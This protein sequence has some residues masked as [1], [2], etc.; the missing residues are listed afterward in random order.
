[1]RKFLLK[2]LLVAVGAAALLLL[3][4][5]IYRLDHA[6]RYHELDKFG[7]IAGF[8]DRILIANVGS[9]HGEYDFSYDALRARG[10]TCFNFGLSSQ[11]FEL[12]YAVLQQY[13]EELSPGGIVFI[14]IS[15]FSFNDEVVSEKEKEERA[16]RYYQF[17]SPQYIPDYDWYVDLTTHRLPI[18][19]A[20]YKV[21]EVPLHLYEQSRAA[22]L[23]TLRAY[24]AESGEQ[25]ASESGAAAGS[26]S[27]AEQALSGNEASSKSESGEEQPD[28]E[29]IARFEEIGLLRYQ[30]H[31]E[32]KSEYF[33]PEQIEFLRRIIQLCREQGM[34]PVL[35]TPPFTHY[36]TDYISADWMYQFYEVIVQICKEEGVTYYD[37]GEDPRF[38]DSLQYFGDPDHLNTEG[39]AYF[40]EI[41]E[42]EIPEFAEALA[43]NQK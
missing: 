19:T 17:L 15:Y 12:D 31:L 30:R 37:Y 41:L 34:T 3:L 28:A 38:T 10:Y 24:A 40:M 18:L 39:A 14:P 36:Y 35:V 23:F 43:Q 5:Q 20:G 33:E 32:N 16:V 26:E 13:R 2:F 27:S 42:Q 9:S 25:E 7:D 11:N 29:T 1:M 22:G 8:D 4:N 6:N 21:L